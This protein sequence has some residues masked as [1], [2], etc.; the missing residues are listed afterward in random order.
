LTDT[1][2]TYAPNRTTQTESDRGKSVN[3]L[4]NLRRCNRSISLVAM[5]GIT[6][7]LS[8]YTEKALFG[9]NRKIFSCG[10][11]VLISVANPVPGSGAFLTPGSGMGKNQV[12]D[13]ESG[14][15]IPD[16]ISESLETN[17]S[18]NLLTLDPG[19]EM[20]KFGSWINIPD[21]QHWL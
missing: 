10:N 17:G 5:N 13:P 16:H 3:Q 1:S 9:S 19:S 18:R 20:K 6:I 12:P 4:V 7:Q 8:K 21:S 2:S 14:M 15:N 11:V